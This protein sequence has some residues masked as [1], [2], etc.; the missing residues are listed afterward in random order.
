MKRGA[1]P[2]PRRARRRTTCPVRRSRAAAP[3]RRRRPAA[4]TR[5]RSGRSRHD[6]RSSW[7]LRRVAVAP[8]R[9]PR[10]SPLRAAF[11]AERRRFLG[12][13][14]GLLGLA[15]ALSISAACAAAAMTACAASAPPI[16][17]DRRQLVRLGARRPR[18]PSASPAWNSA[19][20]V[21][22][23]RPPPSPSALDRRQRLARPRLHLAHLRLRVDVDA[24]AGELRREADVLALL[25]DGQRQLLVGDDELHRVAAGVDDDARDL[26]GRDARCT[27]SAPDRRS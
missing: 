25:A 22:G 23:A 12:G 6:E 21:A 2:R 18:P 7:S 11:S 17:G 10:R 26:G 4:G 24:P 14:R 1:P 19:S 9:P 3:S 5:C 15:R 8:A 27:R 20:T 16:A 13:A